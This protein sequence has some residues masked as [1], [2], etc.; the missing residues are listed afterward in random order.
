MLGSAGGTWLLWLAMLCVCAVA[1][2]VAFHARRGLRQA[3]TDEDRAFDQLLSD[4]AQTTRAVA[5]TRTLAERHFAS[6][7]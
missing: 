6:R 7:H 5:R 2:G 3:E 4:V 1:A